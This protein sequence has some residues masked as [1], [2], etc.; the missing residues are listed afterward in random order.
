MTL[1]DIINE[2]QVNEEWK[3]RYTTFVPKFIHEAIHKTTWSEWEPDIFREY[4]EEVINPVSSMQQG[5]FTHVERT[6]IKDNWSRIA[7]MLRQIAES[8][9]VSLFDVYDQVKKEILELTDSV[10]DASINRLIAGLQPELLTTIVRHKYLS[11]LRQLLQISCGLEL[12]GYTGTSWFK[13]S[14]LVLKAFRSAF[15]DKDSLD[16][17][18]Y[19]WQALEFLEHTNITMLANKIGKQKISA[20]LKYKKQII[21]QG[22]PGTGKTRLAKEIAR[23]LAR[24]PAITIEDIRRIIK[25]GMTVHSVVDNVPYTIT[26]VGDAGVSVQLAN[27]NV[28]AQKY[29]DIIQAYD[30][31]LQ[32]KTFTGGD[33][34][35]QAAVA[36]YIMDQSTEPA[37]MKIIQFHP[38]YTYEDFVSGIVAEG[39]GEKITYTNVHKVFG[40]FAKETAANYFLSKSGNNDQQVDV[41][42][43]QNFNEFKE[44]IQKELE[45]NEVK[46]TS[47]ISIYDIEEKCFRYGKNWA[48]PGRL[49]F[50]DV[51]AIIQ[52]VITG[53]MNASQKDIPKAISLHAHYRYPYY[54][55]LLR[56]FLAKYSF[57][58]APDNRPAELNYVLIID[59][60]NR[61]NLSAVFGELIYALEYRGEKVASMYEVEGT[62]ELILTPNLYIIG[63]MNT[64]DRSVGHID[65]AIRRRFAFVDV[66]PKDLTGARDIVFHQRL[67]NQVSALFDQ[68]RSAEFQKKDIQLGHSYFIDKSA[69]GGDMTMRL[70]FEIKPILREYVKDGILASATIKEEI[71]KLKA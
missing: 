33:T 36:K 54:L 26:A 63:T 24:P 39:E 40:L 2:I 42:I 55:S 12:P 21:L 37:R 58:P 18:T 38:S 34:S 31:L 56:M 16:I 51:K 27:G 45:E 53:Q 57:S 14:H 48:Q 10:R 7:P 6:R 13:D 25:V 46:L 52:A 65:Y 68:H 29:G 64:A 1:Q 59:E 4:F 61:A 49:N 50:A 15:P 11:E 70:E 69:Q 71:E 20:L 3:S 43:D 35:Y 67:F 44:E 8:Q 47:E 9:H 30:N 23:D 60:I 32:D 19:P 66:E 17:I 62:R 22:P 28:Y 41:W 5:Y